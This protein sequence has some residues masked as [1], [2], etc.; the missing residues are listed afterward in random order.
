MASDLLLARIFERITCDALV[1]SEVFETSYVGQSF[2]LG[3]WV[4]AEEWTQFLRGSSPQ[5][6]FITRMVTLETG[7]LHI[8]LTLFPVSLSDKWSDDGRL[9]L[10]KSVLVSATSFHSL[11]DSM[12]LTIMAPHR[13]VPGT[14]HRTLPSLCKGPPWSESV[15]QRARE[16]EWCNEWR[17]V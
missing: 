9:V 17:N 13:K 15:P 1:Y 12:A 7:A 2:E 3:T 8:E 14:H 10:D 16:H 6:G 5:I 4:L 11:I